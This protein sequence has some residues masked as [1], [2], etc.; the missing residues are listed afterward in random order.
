MDNGF[1][2]LTVGPKTQQ[3]LEIVLIEPKPGPML[4]EESAQA[5]RLLLRKGCSVRARS[6]STIAARPTKS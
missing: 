4:D 5:V 3:D 6:K 1:R 2:W